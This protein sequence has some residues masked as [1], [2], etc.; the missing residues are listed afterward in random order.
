[1]YGFNM[2]KLFITM[3]VVLATGV[4]AH[5]DIL[6]RVIH[7]DSVVTQNRSDLLALF[8][9]QGRH[10]GTRYFFNNLLANGTAFLAQPGVVVQVESWED[11]IAT[12]EM[13]NGLGVN[14]SVGYIA[15][16]DLVILN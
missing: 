6:C 3:F 14:V 16:N 5:A 9:L 10:E 2:K 12:I 4:M 1:M 13:L 7:K 11:G 8:L 15:T